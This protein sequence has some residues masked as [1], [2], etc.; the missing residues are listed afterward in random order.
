MSY[1]KNIEPEVNLKLADQIAV[2]PGQIVSKTLA[3]RCRQP[4]AV[5]VGS[6]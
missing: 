5:R 4:D 2:L 3:E 1:I 6:G